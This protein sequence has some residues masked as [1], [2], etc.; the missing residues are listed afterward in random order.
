MTKKLKLGS[1]LLMIFAVLIALSLANSTI[2]YTGMVKSKKVQ[3]K[4][5]TIFLPSLKYIS[6]ILHNQ[7]EI[8]ANEYVLLNNNFTIEDRNFFADM[9]S[10]R[11]TDLESAKQKFDSL[12]KTPEVLELWK[13]YV[14]DYDSWKKK[15]DIFMQYVN[16]RISLTD[17]GVDNKDERCTTLDLKLFEYYNNRFK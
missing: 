10:V 11:F 2:G 17:Q 12:P 7:S 14:T 13:T 6:E 15:H 16:E 5:A 3:D 9:I 4:M 1:K 8:K